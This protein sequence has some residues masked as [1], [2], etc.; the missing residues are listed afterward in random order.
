M[1]YKVVC[2]PKDKASGMLARGQVCA[3]HY[4]GTYYP[5]PGPAIRAAVGWVSRNPGSYADVLTWNDSALVV[6]VR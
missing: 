5:H 6:T 2:Y 4:T 1:G 3:P